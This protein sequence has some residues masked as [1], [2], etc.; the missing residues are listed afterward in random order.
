[1]RA[2][3]NVAVDRR[4]EITV[5]VGGGCCCGYNGVATAQLSAVCRQLSCLYDLSR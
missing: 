1:M 5:R 2:F 4:N 3:A